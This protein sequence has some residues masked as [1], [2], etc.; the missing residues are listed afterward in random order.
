MIGATHMLVGAIATSLGLG[1]SD[2]VLLTVGALASLLPDVDVSVS[3]AGKAFP[4]LSKRLERRFAHRSCTHSL[5]ASLVLLVAS[6]PIP[7]LVEAPLG[8]I[9]AINIGY[10]A[11]YFVDSFTKSG[12]EIFWPHPVRFVCPG[13]RNFRL[14]TGNPV[15]YTILVVLVALALFV[16]NINA[17][18]GMEVQMNRIL[19]TT[20]GVEQLYNQIGNDHLIIVHIQG[21]RNSDRARVN[22]NFWIVQA[23][24]KDFIVQ[25][26]TGKIYKAG[27]EPDAQL[28]TE[29]IIADPGP[30][31]TT[32]IE[33][34]RLED[35]EVRD[36]LSQ[37]N[38]AGAMVFVSGRLAIDDPEGLEFIT[39]P[40]QFPIICATGNSITLE[41][42]PLM[43]V[44]TILGEQF[45][46][47]Q[48]FIRSIYA[49]QQKAASSL[50]S[51][52]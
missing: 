9:H 47:G 4:W 34:L 10:F 37:F 6:Y 2:S 32:A 49:Q 33:P 19:A 45:A 46:T 30:V 31:A 42:A 50:S 51:D 23:H 25:S 28:I 36:S 8:L 26:K 43:T 11:G 13:N 1:T 39:D 44:N 17:N 5:M 15:E 38:R 29:Q 16:F 22:E 21:V 18:G 24:G 48:L 3:T 14:Q 7:I 20:E 41:A 52:A 40:N 27:S 35:Q 12:I